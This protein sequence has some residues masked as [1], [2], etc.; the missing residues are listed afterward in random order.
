MTQDYIPPLR[1]RMIGDMTVRRF[2]AETQCNYIRAVKTFATF[3]GRSPDTATADDLRLFL[4]YLALLEQKTK[5][6]DQAAPLDNWRLTDCVHRLRRLMEA[7]MGNAGRREFFQVHITM[8]SP[9]G[10]CGRSVIIV[11]ISLICRNATPPLIS[12]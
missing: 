2:A 11:S 9:T 3:L 6:L 5:A 10:R 8:A 12:G 4:H 1:R 7:R